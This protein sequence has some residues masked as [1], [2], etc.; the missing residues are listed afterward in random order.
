MKRLAVLFLALFALLPAVW[1]Q[2]EPT[3]VDP[4]QRNELKLPNGKSQRDEI[5]RADYK[6]NVAD[7]EKLAQ[8]SMEIKDEF[9]AGDSN[10]VS[11]KTLKKLEEVQ[12]LA[13]SMQSRMKRY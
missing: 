2:F 7:S 4:T 1:S 5:V 6:K 10:I 3:P 12:R 13:K 11:V 8:L 9:A